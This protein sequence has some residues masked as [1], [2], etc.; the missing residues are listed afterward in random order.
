[1]LHFI[2]AFKLI[3]MKKLFTIVIACLL[4]YLC[5]Y[6]QET[7][8]KY[9]GKT[10]IFDAFE[11]VKN[12]DALGATDSSEITITKG[13][14]YTVERVMNNGDLVIKFLPWG[15]NNQTE[16]KKYNFKMLSTEATK[17]SPLPN[18][19]IKFF[20]LSK[21]TFALS[22]SE[23]NFQ[24]KWDITFGTLT[25][26]F[27]FRHSPFLFTTNLNLGALV[28]FQR[29]FSTNWS[30]GVV[31]GLSLS[32]VTLD[33]FSTKGFVMTT[34]ERP[35]VTPTISGMIGYKNINVTIGFG[36]DIINK[37]SAIEESWMYA[38]K[39]WIGVGIGISL[40]NA[41]STPQTTTPASGQK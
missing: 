10:Y 2:L 38:G 12:C 32:S 16:Q 37:P 20:L 8:Q 24:Q 7:I 11:K 26:P 19:N 30:W 40:F 9:K 17:A 1:M 13:A 21:S 27:K 22:C 31:G 4:T 35:A 29:K 23:Y 3:K 28:A 25:T 14:L 15:K 6:S 33:S 39:R 36:W 34:T 18:D 41:S 5:S